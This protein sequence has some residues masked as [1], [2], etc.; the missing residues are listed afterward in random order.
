MIQSDTSR[1]ILEIGS[2]V[3]ILPV[4]F[5]HGLQRPVGLVLEGIY[6]GDCVIQWTPESLRLL[7]WFQPSLE[8]VH[9]LSEETQRNLT[10]WGTCP[11]VTPPAFVSHMEVQQANLRH[12]F[13]LCERFQ[14]YDP[15]SR[16]IAPA[17]EVSWVMASLKLRF[18]VKWLIAQLDLPFKVEPYLEGVADPL[19]LRSLSQILLWVGVLRHLNLSWRGEQGFDV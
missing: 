14:A 5:L 1:A 4:R 12:L 6:K 17:G 3:Y 8:S 15:L 18:R 16:S 2:R 9:V 10:R 11:G 7:S 13:Y 19:V